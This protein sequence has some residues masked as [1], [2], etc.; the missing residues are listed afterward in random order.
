MRRPTFLVRVFAY[1]IN[2]NGKTLL[3]ASQVFNVVLVK[4]A[5]FSSDIAELGL[6]FG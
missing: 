2:D 1:P 5:D 6:Y 3:M 4:F